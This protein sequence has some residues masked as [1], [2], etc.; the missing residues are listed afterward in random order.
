MNIVDTSRQGGIALSRIAELR[1]REAKVFRKA[2][3][4]SADAVGKGAEGYFGGVPM[5]WMKDWPTPFPIL[6]DQAKG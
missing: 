5:H 6:V 4:K 1:E 2:R 3:P